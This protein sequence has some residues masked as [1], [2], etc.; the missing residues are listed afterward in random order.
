MVKG[1]EGE[2]LPRIPF[3]ARLE[4]VVPAFEE[5]PSMVQLDPW[6]LLKCLFFIFGAKTVIDSGNSQDYGKANCT[7]DELV[8]CYGIRREG[9]RVKSRHGVRVRKTLLHERLSFY[10]VGPVDLARSASEIAKSPPS[11]LRF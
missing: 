11:C 8:V 7:R 10:S 9:S 5:T 6:Q 1:A 3:K 2:A 4:E